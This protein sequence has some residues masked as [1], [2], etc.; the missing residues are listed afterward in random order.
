MNREEIGQENWAKKMGN[1]QTKEEVINVQAGNGEARNSVSLSV[2][3]GLGLLSFVGVL[4]IIL[5]FGIF[6]FVKT[7]NKRLDRR[8]DRRVRAEIRR[9]QELQELA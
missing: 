6:W 4:L 2:Y 7:H 9:S 8:I 5:C 3:E 1:K